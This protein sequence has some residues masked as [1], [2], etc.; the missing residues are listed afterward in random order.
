MLRWDTSHAKLLSLQVHSYCRIVVWKT[1]KRWPLATW[2]R[3]ATLLWSE[4]NPRSPQSHHQLSAG[5]TCSGI[6]PPAIFVNMRTIS[7]SPSIK[8]EKLSAENLRMVN[9]VSGGLEALAWIISDPGDLVI[10]PTPT[11]AR[12]M[13]WPFLAII[14]SPPGFLQT[15][16]RECQQKWWGCIWEKVL[17]FPHSS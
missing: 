6:G 5:E 11:Y 15:W 10:V 9:G 2:V 17:N 16:T 3:L 7:I 12:W 13:M 8:G 14:F 1:E 4:R